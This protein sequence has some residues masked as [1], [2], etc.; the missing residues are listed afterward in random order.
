VTTTIERTN[1]AA[2]RIVDLMQPIPIEATFPPNYAGSGMY[3]SFGHEVW[4]FSVSVVQQPYVLVHLTPAVWNQTGPMMVT[5]AV[6]ARRR[7]QNP[8]TNPLIAVELT[9]G[10]TEALEFLDADGQPF[11]FRGIAESTDEDLVAA[12]FGYFVETS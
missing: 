3:I 7:D 2:G 6:A 11:S 10:S 1:V 8:L 5:N 4:E 9:A 12:G